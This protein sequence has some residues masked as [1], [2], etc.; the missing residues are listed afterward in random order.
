LNEIEEWN[1][2]SMV[3]FYSFCVVNF[4]NIKIEPNDIKSAETVRDFKVFHTILEC[5]SKIK[6]NIPKQYIN[7][8]VII[9][10]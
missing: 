6:K 5:A 3:S 4:S 2:L 1:S 10:N 9:V 7:S 8:M